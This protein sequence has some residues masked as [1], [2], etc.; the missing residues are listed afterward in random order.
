MLDT[1]TSQTIIRYYSALGQSFVSRF[2]LSLFIYSG[3]SSVDP[4][5]PVIFKSTDAMVAFG[6][7]VY[8][9]AIATYIQLT[10]C[11]CYIGL[12]KYFLHV[13][14]IFHEKFHFALTFQ[15]VFPQPQRPQNQGSPHLSIKHAAAAPLPR[16]APSECGMSCV[17][18]AGG[19]APEI[20]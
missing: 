16:G 9:V 19:A 13:P 6:M 2:V 10:R 7:W 14:R 18:G 8:Q 5:R 12:K 11:H 3:W 17:Y 20:F 4:S 1:Y 15:N